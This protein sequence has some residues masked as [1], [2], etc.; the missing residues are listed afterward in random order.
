MNNLSDFSQYIKDLP[1][2]QTANQPWHRT[3]LMPC[4]LL[5]QCQICK[6]YKSVFDFYIIKK[7]TS[8]VGRKA[9]LGGRIHSCCKSCQ[10]LQYKQTSNEQKL[11]NSAKKRAKQKNLKFEIKIEDIKIPEFCPMLGIPLFPASGKNAHDNSPTLDRLDSNLG[12]TPENI[13][14]IS[15]R[16]NTIKGNATPEELKII[17]L[18]AEGLTNPDHLC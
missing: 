11:F 2:Y 8:K 3:K 10:S 7:L 5:N 17:A 6:E 9:S 16:A 15:H 18:Y 12:Y 14:V 13:L 4:P 1:D